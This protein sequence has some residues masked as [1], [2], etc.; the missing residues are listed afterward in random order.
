MGK[1]SDTRYVNT[2]DSLVNA[3]KSKLE[4]P[5]YQFADKKPTKVTY[6]SQNIEK[7][8]LDESSG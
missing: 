2:I 4:N 1:F 6:Y 3:T 5:Y 7:S 8:T